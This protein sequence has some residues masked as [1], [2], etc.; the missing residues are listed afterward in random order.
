MSIRIFCALLTLICFIS[1][2]GTE[3]FSEEKTS[4][5]FLLVPASACSVKEKS[6]VMRKFCSPVKVPFDLKDY[7]IIPS[8]DT[9][10]VHLAIKNS[11]EDDDLE[12]LC[13]RCTLE[14]GSKEK[15]GRYENIWGNRGW[16]ESCPKYKD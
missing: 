5:T 2:H 12:L 10:Y 7:S 6:P 9:G 16:T 4:N 8:A 14:K 3:A 13:Y 11:T 15:C 1:M